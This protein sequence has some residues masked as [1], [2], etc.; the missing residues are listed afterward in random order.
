MARNVEKRLILRYNLYNIGRIVFRRGKMKILNKI[1]IVIIAILIA[2]ATFSSQ[3]FA[4]ME[5][6]TMK[7]QADGF[8]TT[9]R[10]NGGETVI[11]EASLQNFAMPIARALIALATGILTVI[12]VVMGIQYIMSKPDDKA[13]IKQRLVGLV[14]S[15]IVVYGAQGIWALIYNFMV[16]VTA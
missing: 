16:T 13:K 15:T 3:T 4:M 10:D 1:I 8:I 5:W 7:S 14:V 12:T 6:D 11:S 2:T 9:G